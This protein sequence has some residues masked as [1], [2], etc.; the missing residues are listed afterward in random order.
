MAG[1][2]NGFEGLCKREE[3]IPMSIAYHYVIHQEA[4]CIID[5]HFKHVINTVTEIIN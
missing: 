1:S 2:R 5:I 4:L 3:L